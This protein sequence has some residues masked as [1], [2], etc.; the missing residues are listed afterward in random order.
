MFSMQAW[1][2][3]CY[4][5]STFQI[6]DAFVKVIMHTDVTGCA[7]FISDKTEYLKKYIRQLKNSVKEV[8][9]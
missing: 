4:I 8:I 3:K 5:L 1:V 9:L 6:N 2:F 7:I